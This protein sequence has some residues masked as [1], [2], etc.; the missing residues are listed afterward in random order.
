MVI[1][2]KDIL[3]N[4]IL[5][6]ACFDVKGT[7]SKIVN[8]TISTYTFCLSFV[9]LNARRN[10]NGFQSYYAKHLINTIVECPIYQDTINEIFVLRLISLLEFKWSFSFRVRYL[11]VVGLL[12]RMF[13]LQRIYPKLQATTQFSHCIGRYSIRILHNTLVLSIY[14]LKCFIE[15][16]INS[17]KFFFLNRSQ[18]I[19]HAYV[20]VYLQYYLYQ[21]L[22]D[23][24][25]VYV[26]SNFLDVSAL[27]EVSDFLQQVK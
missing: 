21:P 7:W 26:C 20:V 27:Q 24:D 14:L 9:N 17:F 5:V 19:L 4:S 15:I 6:T 8:F 3:P 16:K 23:N 10:S 1:K 13:S 18:S 22:P 11:L 25:S 12:Q 2:V